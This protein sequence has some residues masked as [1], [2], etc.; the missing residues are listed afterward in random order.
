MGL[1][2][3]RVRQLGH[4]IA[5]LLILAHGFASFEAS[6]FKSA[7]G[8]IGVALLAFIVAGL[9]KRIERSFH[10]GDV[11]FYLLEAV[12]LS[13]SAFHYQEESKVFLSYFTGTAAVLFFIVAIVC[14]SIN[15]EPK[16]KR[17]RRYR[18]KRSQT[19]ANVLE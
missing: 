2:K 4:L 17:S 11:A 6:D 8:Y 18:R 1:K 14:L 3:N 16:R 9:Y 12:T 13:Y 19:T 7:G 10:N 5:G 15:D